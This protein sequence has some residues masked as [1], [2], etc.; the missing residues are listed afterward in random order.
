MCVANCYVLLSLT[1]CLFAHLLTCWTNKNLTFLAA[2]EV[3]AALSCKWRKVIKEVRW[4][5]WVW[6]GE[7]FFWYWPT[8]VVPDKR[9]LNGCW[10]CLSVCLCVQE[11]VCM[12]HVIS[13]CLSRGMWHGPKFIRKILRL[14]FWEQSFV[15]IMTCWCICYKSAAYLLRYISQF[16]AVHVC[17]IAQFIVVVPLTLLVVVPDK[18][19]LNVCV[20]IHCV[21]KKQDTKLLP[22]TS[23]N[24]NRFSKFFHC[25]THW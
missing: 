19:P 21:S 11:Y 13:V 2:F 12:W 4:P 6:A 18:G 24:V 7:C 5:G 9:P 20:Y 10:N 8:R 23:P 17:Y 15:H 3:R 25:Q 1:T 22:I 16:I 14:G